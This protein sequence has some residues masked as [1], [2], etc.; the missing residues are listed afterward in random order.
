MRQFLILTAAVAA[1][2]F[3]A[4]AF[5]QPAPQGVDVNVSIGPSLQK[6][7]DDFGARELNDISKDLGDSVRHAVSR[8][9]ADRPVRVEL[10]IEDAV[11]NRPTFA[12]LSRTPGLS[13]RSIGVGGAR[14]SGVATYADGSQRP[15]R[16]QFYET[17][18]REERGASTWYDADRAFDQVASDIGRGKLPASYQGPGP[19][20]GNGHFGYPFTNQ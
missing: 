14:I 4:T 8:S 10:V 1:L 15:I 7:A 11:P 3:G 2:G 9:R 5:A 19:G 12:Q 6:H 18:L 17:D 16:E 13:L 20:G